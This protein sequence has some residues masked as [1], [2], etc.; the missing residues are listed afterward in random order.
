MNKRYN[1]KEFEQ[2]KMD[3]KIPEIVQDKVREA[4]RKIESGQLKQEPVKSNWIKTGL[5]IV[6]SMAAVLA[7]AVAVCIANPVM[8]EQLPLVGNLFSKLQDQVSFR[9][10]FSN[11]ATLLEDSSETDSGEK[12][13]SANPEEQTYQK[14]DSG[15]TVTFSEVYANDQAMYLT[16]LVESEE[17]FPDNVMKDQN[18][19]PVLMMQYDLGF[20]FMEDTEKSFEMINPEGVF[21]DDHTYTC[22]LRVSLDLKDRTEYE[23]KYNEMVQQVLDEMGI[24]MDD[25]DDETEEGYAN[26]EKFNDEVI[27]R[28]GALGKYIKDIQ[29]PEEFKVNLDINLLEFSLEEEPSETE[30]EERA[31]RAYEGKWCYEVPVK[32]DNSQTTVVEINETNEDGIGLASVVKTPYEI[33]VNELYEDGSGS[34]TFLVALDADGN[35]LPYNDSNVDCNNFTIQNRDVSKVD[36]YILDYTTYMDGGI[37]GEERF[38]GNENRPEE[39]KWGTLLMQHAKYHKTVTFE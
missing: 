26:L 17:A 28:A 30:S 39:E 14:T 8:A 5:K 35:R 3:A 15:L 24:T 33:T 6:C 1:E 36:I 31:V 22:I 32:I 12:D 27:G 11:K 19:Q 23:Q 10:D 25:I 38:N 37:K 9:G 16:V 13:A 20:D 2:L 4:Y 29:V 18:D 34:D 7:V 21:I